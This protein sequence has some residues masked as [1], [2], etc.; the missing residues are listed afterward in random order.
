MWFVDTTFSRFAGKVYVVR[1]TDGRVMVNG[2]TQQRSLAMDLAYVANHG[3]CTIRNTRFG[4]V[5]VE[6]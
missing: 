4:S 3:S 5:R 6:H 2:A 1:C